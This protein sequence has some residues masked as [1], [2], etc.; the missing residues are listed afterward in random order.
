MARSFCGSA[1]HAFDRRGFLG[2]LA[3]GAAAFAA[4]MTTPLNALAAPAMAGGL[5]KQ[6]KRVI[7]LWLAGGSSQL[8]T[9]DPKPG[10]ATGGPFASIPTTVPG[11]HLS[12]LMPR[13]AERLKHICLIR[14][15]NTKNADHGAA[16]ELMMRGR[17]DE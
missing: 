13:M 15:L 10:T 9:W 8:E 11:V 14:S 12:E 17:Q 2:T 5:K 7:L 4:D 1:D 6:E 16:A 3:A